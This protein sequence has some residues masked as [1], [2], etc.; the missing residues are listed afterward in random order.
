MA[1]LRVHYT[2]NTHKLLFGREE[3]YLQ[4]SKDRLEFAKEVLFIQLSLVDKY[5]CKS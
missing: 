4:F 1:A 2:V 3:N 5:I